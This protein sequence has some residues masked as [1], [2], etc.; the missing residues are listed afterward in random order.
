MSVPS[1]L[2]VHPEGDSALC[3]GMVPSVTGKNRNSSETKT[4]AFPVFER[5]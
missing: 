4:K 3:L 2:L 1:L 5:A